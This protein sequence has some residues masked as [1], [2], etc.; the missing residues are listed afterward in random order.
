MH[1][2]T[3]AV[4]DIFTYDVV[5]EVDFI[6]AHNAC[7]FKLIW[8]IITLYTYI[9][10][11][12]RVAI[13]HVCTWVCHRDAWRYMCIHGDDDDITAITISHDNHQTP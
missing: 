13:L 10:I 5:E 8:H 4:N 2:N 7:I 12:T 1:E 11:Y 9:Y 3:Y 6:D